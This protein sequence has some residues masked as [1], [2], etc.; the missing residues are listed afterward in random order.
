MTFFTVNFNGS[1]YLFKLRIIYKYN[2]NAIAK[3]SH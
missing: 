3:K 2:D 1:N